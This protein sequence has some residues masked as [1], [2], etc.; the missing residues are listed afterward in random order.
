MNDK[1]EKRFG[2]GRML[3][4]LSA[5]IV[6]YCLYWAGGRTLV[7]DQVTALI[8]DAKS[9]GYA[10]GHNGLAIGGFPTHF[11]IDLLNPAIS[12]PNTASIRLEDV[13]LSAMS[14]N[15]LQWSSFHTGDARVDMRGLNNER[16]LFD[17]RPFNAFGVAQAGLTGDVKQINFGARRLKAQ[18]VIG[19]LPP[20]IAIDD[21]R[22]FAA[23]NGENPHIT[24]DFAALYLNTKSA[25]VWQ[26]AFG[27]RID[28]IKADI[29]LVG[30]KGLD[31]ESRAA[32]S[33]QA[34]YVSDHWSLKWGSL[35]LEGTFDLQNSET[36]VSG[37]IITE[38]EDINTI[39]AELQRAGILTPSQVAITRFAIIS[40]P[41]NEQG[42]QEVTLTIQDGFLVAFGQRLYKF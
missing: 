30:L 36:G 1:V 4:L 18:A 5:L 11:K 26:K 8:S 25:P 28:S 2:F 7:A 24:L 35:A 27:P 39:M 33:D 19:T 14:L 41:V 12:S 40:L 16:W 10:V 6:L 9:R 42:R 21:A 29:D 31:S 34:H 17:I 20:V 22:I 13:E 32:W 38:V 23:N 3:L 37:K 15:P